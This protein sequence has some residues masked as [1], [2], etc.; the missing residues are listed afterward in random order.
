ML[1]ALYGLNYVFRRDS[2]HR[3]GIFGKGDCGDIHLAG[4]YGAGAFVRMEDD[5]H[6][7]LFVAE[8][9][10]VAHPLEPSVFFGDG[11]LEYRVGIIF[12]PGSE[13]R[14]CC[15]HSDAIFR[16]GVAVA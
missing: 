8:H 9:G 4:M 16:T 10:A 7:A 11:E 5:A 1:L 13:R 6:V 14:G 12:G 2:H 3:H 15:C